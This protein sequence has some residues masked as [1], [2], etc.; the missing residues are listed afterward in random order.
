MAVSYKKTRPKT[1]FY[2]PEIVTIHYYELDKSFVFEGEAHDFWEMVYVDKGAVEIQADD[3]TLVLNQG[4]VLFHKPHEFHAIRAFRSNPNFFVI[5]FVC[6]SP[7]M[8]LFEGYRAA[9]SQ[10]LRPFVSS[11]ITEA[12]NSFHIP[13]NDVTLL[14]LRRRSQ[15][16]E[17]GEQLIKTYLEQ[18]LILL[19]RVIL[20]QKDNSVSPVRESMETQLI[21]TIKTYIQNNLGK[22]IAMEELAGVTGY[23]TSYISRIFRQQC[24]T[25]IGKYITAK[26]ITYAKELIRNHTYNMA[27]IAD[28][29]AFD[30]PQYFAGT[31]KKE[32]GMTP[33]EFKR[34]LDIK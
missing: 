9:L 15:A 3:K 23:S 33:S 17:G 18:L 32:T 24:G 6:R 1:L 25:T 27:Q 19:A 13:K 16:K 5:S 8:R 26:K 31:F 21:S 20:E 11:I 10:S 30:T 22:K 34:S 4:E 7:A 2:I 14:K 28:M 29:L 12:R